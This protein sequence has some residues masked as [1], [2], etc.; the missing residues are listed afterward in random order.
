[1]GDAQAEKGITEL[2]KA[3]LERLDRFEDSAKR[4]RH[5]LEEI[6]TVQEATSVQI[7]SM[8][9]FLER[10]E[11]GSRGSPQATCQ[12]RRLSLESVVLPR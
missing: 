4:M 8:A 3:M 5:K 6:Q 10:I 1:M 7:A 9:K 11:R 2:H 12:R